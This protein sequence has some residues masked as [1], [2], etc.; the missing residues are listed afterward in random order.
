[1][2]YLNANNQAII[3]NEKMADD[4]KVK[5][6]SKHALE[7]DKLTVIV[8]NNN[9]VERNI[10]MSRVATTTLSAGRI[11]GNDE[12][13][14]QILREKFIFIEIMKEILND[15]DIPEAAYTLHNTEFTRGLRC[16]ILYKSNNLLYPSVIIE[17]QYLVDTKMEDRLALYALLAK[18]EYML[19]SIITIVVPV[20]RQTGSSLRAYPQNSHI[21]YIKMHSS[22]FCMTAAYTVDLETCM[23]EI[24]QDNNILE[25]SMIASIVYTFYLGSNNLSV[26]PL[27]SK[28]IDQIYTILCQDERGQHLNQLNHPTV[29]LCF[30]STTN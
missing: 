27:K 8:Q 24:K 19:S 14:K 17:I 25:R 18:K 9:D 1:M 7:P 29:K 3:Q 20:V 12:T 28:F 11:P 15:K 30:I 21:K 2:I 13:S 5:Y 23:D 22:P 10:L 16:D 4:F 6:A 26:V